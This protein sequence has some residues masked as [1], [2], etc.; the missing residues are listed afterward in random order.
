M[1]F[2]LLILE[3]FYLFTF[4]TFACWTFDSWN[5][6]IY[7]KMF[8]EIK[9]TVPLLTFIEVFLTEYFMLLF[10]SF[11]FDLPKMVM[12]YFLWNL[13]LFIVEWTILAI[14]FA[15]CWQDLFFPEMGSSRINLFIFPRQKIWALFKKKIK[16]KK[17]CAFV[18]IFISVT[19]R[20]KVRE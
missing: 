12:I 1:V 5:I 6:I 14:F 20:E 10:L 19:C 8:W 9:N 2:P 13:L 16:G 15:K 3:L 11:L 7:D 4:L 18:Y 17:I